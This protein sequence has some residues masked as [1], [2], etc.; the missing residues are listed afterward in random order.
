MKSNILVKGL[1]FALMAGTLASCSEDYLSTKPVT[2]LSTNTVLGDEN[3]IEMAMNGLCRSMYCQYSTRGI[4]EYLSFN[5]ESWFQMFY[6]DILGQDYYSN[7]YAQ[8]IGPN[9][10]WVSMDMTQGWVPSVAWGYCYN[11]INQANMIL[12]NVDNVTGDEAKLKRVKAVALTFRAHAYSRLMQTHAPRWQDSQ[13]GEA[14]TIVL[15]LQP[16][17]EELPLVSMNEVLNQ[18]YADLDQAIALYEESKVGRGGLI[19]MPDANVA[20]GIYARTAL[21]K[22]DWA[23]AADHA[24]KARAGHNVMTAAEYKGGFA[25]PVS[26]YIWANAVDPDG[27]A[28][29]A[30]GSWFACQGAYPTLWGMGSGAINYELYK[31]I[32][33]TDI[34]KELYFGPGK[35][36]RRPLNNSAFWNGTICNPVNMDI[37][38]NANMNISVSSWGKSMIPNGDEAKWGLPFKAKQSGGEDKIVI[39]FGAQVKFWGLDPY[40]SNSFPFMR[41]AEF[42]LAEAE[43]QYQLGNEPAAVELLKELMAERDPN[44]SC[45]KSGQ[46]L[47]DEIRLQRRIELWGEGHSWFDLKRWNLPMDRNPWIEGDVNSNNIPKAQELHMKPSDHHGWRFA[48]PKREATYNNAVRLDEV[49]L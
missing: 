20:H 30:H 32:S 43:A 10:Q 22:E 13:N 7:L 19:W 4:G 8:Q 1:A 21:V 35:N 40:G 31:Q 49:G 29:W 24:A 42:L 12:A 14:K 36:L 33:D 44:Y 26:G 17:V 39:P 48:V 28:F 46:A 9:F 34:R 37:S 16:G 11:L 38:G 41:A 23:T 5:G 6:G 47:L 27:L 18:I 45:D 25:E 3:G 2:S 15:R